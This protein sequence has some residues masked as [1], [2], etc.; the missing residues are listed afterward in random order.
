MIEL[1]TNK[2]IVLSC[3]EL[4]QRIYWR[5][6]YTVSDE[7]RMWEATHPQEKMAWVMA[8]DAFEHIHQTDVPECLQEWLA[9]ES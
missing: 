2:G 7:Y 9:D 5:L 3:N 8:C 1:K 4:A 6:G